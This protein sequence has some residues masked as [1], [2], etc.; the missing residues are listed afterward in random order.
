M[1]KTTKLTLVPPKNKNK[2]DASF[3]EN[4]PPRECPCINFVDEGEGKE[5]EENSEGVDN[6]ETKND[7]DDLEKPEKVVERVEKIDWDTVTVD[8]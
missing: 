4:A 2:G 8:E 7:M 5:V 1:L 6:K 3:E